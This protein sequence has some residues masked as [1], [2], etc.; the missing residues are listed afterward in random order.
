MMAHDGR[1]K[2]LLADDHT[3]FRQGL[4]EMLGTGGDIEVVGEASDGEEA[5]ALA[6]K[7]K[8]DVVILDVEMP[9]MG[10]AE[11]MDLLL[12]VSP[13]PRVI[14]LTM[15]D[16]PRLVRE[17][18][19]RGASG[20]LSKSATL[21]G[22][23]TAVRTAAES[24]LGPRQE[25][26]VLAV[27]RAVLERVESEVEGDPSGRELEILLLAARGLSNRQI[28]T[29]LTISEGTVKRHLAN[30]YAKIEVGS[31]GEATRKA[32]SEG[33]ITTRDLTQ[34]LKRDTRVSD[35]PRSRS[36]PQARGN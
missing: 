5:V 2:V 33:W 1:I 35:G 26:V 8:P 11:A 19:G 17:F 34:E 31:R 12:K 29:T 14:I 7:I 25:N 3:M 10:A 28:A 27:P 13:T 24:P 30:L 36:F 9:V 6:K 15:H 23:L 22:L 20:Y 18:L 21:E 32:L 4:K 16:N